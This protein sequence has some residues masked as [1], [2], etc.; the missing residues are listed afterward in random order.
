MDGT[1]RPF[2]EIREEGAALRTPTGRWRA[3]DVEAA[4]GE[5]VS[6]EAAKW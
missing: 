6:S 1:P 3:P 2:E 5:A 4:S